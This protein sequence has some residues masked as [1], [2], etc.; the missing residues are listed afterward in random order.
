MAVNGK[1]LDDQG[2]KMSK[3]DAL[4]SQKELIR[5]F[6]RLQEFRVQNITESEAQRVKS[7]QLNE[8]NIAGRHQ[9]ASDILEQSS[10]LNLQANQELKK[11]NF[12][13]FKFESSQAPTGNP[14]DPEAMLFETSNI[15]KTYLSKLS[16]AIT[17]LLKIQKQEETERF[18]RKIRYRFIFI[19]VV[20]FVIIALTS[21]NDF[22]KKYNNYILQQTADANNVI[23][24]QTVDANN[25]ILTQTAVANN[26]ILTQTAVANNIILTQTAVSNYQQ[27]MNLIEIGKCGEAYSIYQKINN[28]PTQD[29]NI[30]SKLALKCGPEAT[31]IDLFSAIQRHDAETINLVVISNKTVSL[32]YCGG[33]A[34]ECLKSSYDNYGELQSL[35]TSIERSSDKIVW[36]YLHTSWSV[37]GTRCQKYVLVHNIIWQV[38]DFTF[39][40]NT[41]PI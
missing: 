27:M 20:I 21:I 39:P 29:G 17:E 38:D 34:R 24:T 5:A 30:Q 32:V 18:F 31:V 7:I 14:S 9:N 8:T 12:Q 37:V 10:K 15:N 6:W 26:I 22:I 25:V 41:C 28:S 4:N 11:V 19:C 13:E 1:W 36:V 33:E 3:T 35:S 40:E 2:K 23:L 16:D